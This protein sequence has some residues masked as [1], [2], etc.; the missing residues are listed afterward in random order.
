MLA[1]SSNACGTLE[2]GARRE[3]KGVR[4]ERGRGER[5]GERG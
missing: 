4:G 5:G 3:E 1:T 2:K